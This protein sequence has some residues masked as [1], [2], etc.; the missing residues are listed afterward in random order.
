MKLWKI[1]KFQIFYEANILKKKQQQKCESI[2][3]EKKKEKS[4][5]K[6]GCH[7]SF[8]K[9]ILIIIGDELFDL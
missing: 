9:K 8:K 3:E 2:M 4:C 6:V 7:M 1:L 5:G